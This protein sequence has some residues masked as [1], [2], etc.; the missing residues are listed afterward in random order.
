LFKFYIKRY[1]TVQILTNS[2]NNFFYFLKKC[3]RNVFDTFN[4]PTIIPII[5]S[6]KGGGEMMNITTY[7]EGVD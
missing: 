6:M 7:M 2:Q 5:W 4:G 3:L 1:F